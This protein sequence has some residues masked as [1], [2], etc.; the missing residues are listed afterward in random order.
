ML[1]KT[2]GTSPYRS[3]CDYLAA[4]ARLSEFDGEAPAA[5]AA[6]AKRQAQKAKHMVSKRVMK[7]RQW[8]T[9]QARSAMDT[10]R[11]SF[12]KNFEI[13]F[14]RVVPVIGGCEAQYKEGVVT[15][16]L[17]LKYRPKI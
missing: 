2:G 10:A 8:R 13:S 5:E 15:G 4:K 7:L 16:N 17:Q 14:P 3:Q 6:L 9:D 1:L 12:V 11:E